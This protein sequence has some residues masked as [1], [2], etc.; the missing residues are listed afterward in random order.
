MYPEQ[1]F[2]SALQSAMHNLS[3]VSAITNIT[4]DFLKKTAIWCN[5]SIIFSLGIK[6]IEVNIIILL[7]FAWVIYNDA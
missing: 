1:D 3:Y 6:I 4:R 7:A 2:F 5:D